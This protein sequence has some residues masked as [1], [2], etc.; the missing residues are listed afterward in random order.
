MIAKETANHYSSNEVVQA[1]VTFFFSSPS[2]KDQVSFSHYLASVVCSRPFILTKVISSETTESN[3]TEIVNGV[4]GLKPV[5][6][7]PCC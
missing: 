1:F 2:H 3:L 4:Y 6:D 5:Y 7:D